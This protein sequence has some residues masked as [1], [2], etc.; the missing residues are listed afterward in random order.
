PYRPHPNP[1]AVIAAVAAS[2]GDL[3]IFR[4]DPRRGTPVADAWWEGLTG[5]DQPKVIARLPFIERPRHPAGTP[6]FVVAKP[7]D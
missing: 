2:R 1:A 5:E 3:G 4:F 6:V 7:L